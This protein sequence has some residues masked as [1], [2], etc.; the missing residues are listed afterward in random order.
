MFKTAFGWIVGVPAI[1]A[2]VSSPSGGQTKP[3]VITP[4]VD[5]VAPETTSEP[6]LPVSFS[7]EPS[8]AYPAV[9]TAPPS[10]SITVD[11]MTLQILELRDEM[12]GTFRS[13]NQAFA[14]YEEVTG[15]KQ[16]VT[17]REIVAA[18]LAG[19]SS[20]PKSTTTDLVTGNTARSANVYTPQQAAA[21]RYAT[22]RLEQAAAS[23]N[24]A[25]LTDQAL[26]IRTL[27][28]SVAASTARPKTSL[29]KPGGKTPLP[30]STL[31]R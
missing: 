26:Q 22:D 15:L 27:A 17:D 10:G 3:F 18:A 6:I 30:D 29:A 5:L 13:E 16:Q 2:L 28:K 7:T 12:A 25:E 31:L 1:V 14:L 24:R 20:N 19:L 9:P 11:P 4:L 8:V 21:L 23:L